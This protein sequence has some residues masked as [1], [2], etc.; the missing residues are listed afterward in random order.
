MTRQLF[1]D[2]AFPWLQGGQL[3]LVTHHEG[4]PLDLEYSLV[5]AAFDP[6]RGEEVFGATKDTLL[7]LMR[8]GPDGDFAHFAVRNEVAA[9]LWDR[10]SESCAEMSIP[11]RV[12]DGPEFSQIR[13]IVQED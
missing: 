6:S 5:D 9:L 3:A 8:P 10:L 1:D 7:A 4:V 11:L 12:V 13:W 2:P